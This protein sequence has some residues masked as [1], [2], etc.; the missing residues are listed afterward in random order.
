[1]STTELS[2]TYA[3]HETISNE[4]SIEQTNG[5]QFTPAAQVAMIGLK[6][7]VLAIKQHVSKN[8]GQ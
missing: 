1:M 6:R 7:V 4:S 5:E 2:P 8:G 3:A